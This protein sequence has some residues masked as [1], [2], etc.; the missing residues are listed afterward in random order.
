MEPIYFYKMSG[1]GNDFIL[2]DGRTLSIK[3]LNLSDL[4]K[5]LCHRTFGIGADGLIVLDKAEEADFR[6][7][8][9]NADGSE[10]E[11][12]GN[13]GR[14]AARLANLIGLAPQRMSFLTKAGIIHAEV[15]G[16]RVKLELTPPFGLKLGIRLSLNDREERVHFVNTGVPH[17]VFV[18]EDLEGIAI[19]ETGKRVRFH[20]YFRP[21]GT[22]VNFIKIVGPNEIHIRTYERGVEDETLACGTGSVASAIIAYKLNRVTPPVKV[23]TK[24]GEILE[25][26]FDEDLN[27]VFLKGDTRLICKGEVLEEVF[28]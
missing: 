1:S 16:S 13:G 10:A 11:M 22:N 27:Q 24:S 7:Y 14:C 15:D 5:R 6:W 8:F 4:A 23:K 2:I 3:E 28:K 19:K 9:F 21:A 26:F 12:C 25:V 17:T 20:E 18:V